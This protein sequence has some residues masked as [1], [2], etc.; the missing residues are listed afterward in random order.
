MNVVIIIIVI[1]TGKKVFHIKFKE[2]N[3]RGLLYLIFIIFIIT[4]IF[5][6]FLDYKLSGPSILHSILQLSLFIILFFIVSKLFSTFYKQKMSRLI[7]EEL[8]DIL[9]II[10]E[11]ETKGVLINQ[12]SM[13]NKLN[14]T[15][16]TIKKRVNNLMEL[17]YI[18]FEEKGNHKYIR[19]T[20]LGNS[21]IK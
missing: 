5:D 11:A 17:Q 20:P 4:E 8:M 10:K 18:F 2:Y 7:P 19:I 14:I 21:I 3:D 9:R 13:R 12:R 15:K 1:E 6:D 16:P